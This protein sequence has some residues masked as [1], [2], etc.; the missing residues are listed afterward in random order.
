MGA[1]RTTRSRFLQSLT[2]LLPWTLLDCGNVDEV[3]W[4]MHGGGEIRVRSA[5]GRGVGVGG[6]WWVVWGGLVDGGFGTAG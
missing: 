5:C 2:S 3:L 1:S 6:E 4:G